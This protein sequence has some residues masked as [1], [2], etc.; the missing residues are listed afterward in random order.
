MNARIIADPASNVHMPPIYRLHL[1]L[2]MY[3]AFGVMNATGEQSPRNH[4]A[5]VHAGRKKLPGLDETAP[6]AYTLK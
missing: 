5:M 4:R 6:D 2:L 1:W 3:Y